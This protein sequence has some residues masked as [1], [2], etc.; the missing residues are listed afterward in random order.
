MLVIHITNFTLVLV[1]IYLFMHK[2]EIPKSHLG[3]ERA[4]SFKGAQR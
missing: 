2:K 4:G 3:A 1:K